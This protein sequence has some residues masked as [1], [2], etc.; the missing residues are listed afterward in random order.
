M[1]KVAGLAH[2]DRGVV[3]GCVQDIEKN[4]CVTGG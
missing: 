4:V 2:T 1:Q 3:Q